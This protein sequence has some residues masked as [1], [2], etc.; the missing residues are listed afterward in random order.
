MK[1]SKLWED[2]QNSGT[3]KDK[4]DLMEYTAKVD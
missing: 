2:V 3:P 4:V 1:Y